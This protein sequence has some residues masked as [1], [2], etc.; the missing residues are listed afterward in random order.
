MLLIAHLRGDADRVADRVRGL[1]RNDDALAMGDKLI[2]LVDDQEEV[3]DPTARALRYFGYRVVTALGGQEALALVESEPEIAVLI[4]DMVMP[5]MPGDELVRR[6]RGLRPT[7][8][9]LT[10]SGYHERSDNL[11]DLE[12]RG[13]G[14]IRKPYLPEELAAAVEKLRCKDQDR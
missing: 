9:V 11:A 1:E 7:L 3:L 12:Q 4:T 10:V 2:L 6:A 5:G 14:F 13:L 8:P